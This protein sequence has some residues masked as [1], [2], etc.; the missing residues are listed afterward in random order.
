[1]NLYWI[2]MKAGWYVKDNF[3]EQKEPKA[4]INLTG[5]MPLTSSTPQKPD[6]KNVKILTNF[7]LLIISA[8]TRGGP[9]PKS[10][11]RQWPILRI[12]SCIT[13]WFPF[14]LIAKFCFLCL[15]LIRKIH[16][17]GGVDQRCLE[18]GRVSRPTLSSHERVGWSYV[19]WDNK[20]SLLR[21]P[22]LHFSSR[23]ST[24]QIAWVPLARTGCPS[25]TPSHLN[26]QDRPHPIHRSH[27]PILAIY[28]LFLIKGRSGA[29]SVV[30]II[31][32][33]KGWK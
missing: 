12:G 7:R 21:G 11:R 17:W 3:N 20:I 2:A 16:R 29:K 14:Q 30:S 28:L 6:Q 8:Y 18:R 15:S 33:V 23:S 31:L 32:K 19:F 9:Q 13:P 22:L 26:P 4:E 10:A 27:L 5:S 25:H 24:Y 1:M